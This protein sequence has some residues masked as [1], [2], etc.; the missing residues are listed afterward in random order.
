M[1]QVFRISELEKKELLAT[2]E[3]GMPEGVD[4]VYYS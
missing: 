2:V 1:I 3:P 4:L